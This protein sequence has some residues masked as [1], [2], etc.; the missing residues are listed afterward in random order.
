[1]EYTKKEAKAY[2]KKNMTGL[3]G[4]TPYPFLKNMDLDEKGL[5]SDLNYYIETIKIDGFYMGGIIN[6]FWALT[7]EERKRAQELLIQTGKGRVNTITMTGHTSIKTAVEL[8]Q[9]AERLGAD[10]IALM[11][12]Y[13][14]ART[15]DT[16]Y[17][18]F[19]AIA[20]EIDIGILILNSPTA[21]YTLTPQQV[22]KIAE[23]DNICAI[24]N[25]TSSEHTNQARRLIGDQI[26]VSDPNEDNWL[27]NRSFNNQQVFMASPSPHLLQW[28]NH[29]PIVEYTRTLDAGNLAEAKKISAQLDKLRAVTRR[30]IWDPWAA[31]SLPMA[32]LKY[33]QKLIGMAGGYVRSPLLEMTEVEKTEMKKDLLQAGVPVV[34]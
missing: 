11:N 12:P 29:L 4:S 1:M 19:R 23:I 2:A 30:W 9:H 31:G 8:S 16:I 7:L 22:A 34:A 17:E 24:K 14:A 20:S 3:W 27:V 26:V 25:D 28:K 21:G 13:Y 32:R 33:W 18:Y 6:E 10:Y 15:P 5:V